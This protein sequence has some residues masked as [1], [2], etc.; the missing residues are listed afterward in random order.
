M[1]ILRNLRPFFVSDAHIL[2][3]DQREI[4][5]ISPFSGDFSRPGGMTF[6][7]SAK[8]DSAKRLQQCPA[9]VII[10]DLPLSAPEADKTYILTSKP[11]LQIA[12]FSHLFAKPSQNLAFRQHTNPDGSQSEIY[13]S[14]AAYIEDD[15]FIGDGTRIYAGSVVYRGV[16][17]GRNCIL[18]SNCVIGADGFGFEQDE[19]GDW[20][21]IAHLG[22]VSI[23]DAV[24]IGAGTCIDRGTFDDT[25]VGDNVKID[26]LVHIAHNCKIGR[27]TQITAQT[28][29]A[30]SV[31]V[32]ESVWLSPCSAVL[33]GITIGNEAF[34]GMSAVVVKDVA[35]ESVVMGFPARAIMRSPAS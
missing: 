12:K 7:M 10:T 25:V 22:G 27:N 9:S 15:V 17:I 1:H 20:F 16:R 4:S 2:G 5:Y 35:P 18:H 14:A 6:A 30:G 3:D 8:I 19:N 24:E 31:S 21:K 32:G 23:G 29:L 34:V 11:R 28:M 13:C 26:N 33:N